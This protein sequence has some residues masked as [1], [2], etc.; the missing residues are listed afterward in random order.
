MAVNPKRRVSEHFR[1]SIEP[2][3]RCS[4][5]DFQANAR[6][7]FLATSLACCEQSRT[8]SCPAGQIAGSCEADCTEKTESW[9]RNEWEL[10]KRSPYQLAGSSLW[11]T[12]H[13]ASCHPSASCVDKDTRVASDKV[14]GGNICTPAFC[15]DLRCATANIFHPCM[16][17]WESWDKRWRN[18]DRGPYGNGRLHM[19]STSR[20]VDRSDR[21]R[22]SSASC[23]VPAVKCFWFWP[24][25]KKILINSRSRNCNHKSSPQMASNLMA[26]VTFVGAIRR[27]FIS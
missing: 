7:S 16:S 23:C 6:Q 1:C 11:G 24:N 18:A 9:R 22:C 8:F 26:V 25:W 3:R 17:L 20:D 13:T 15:G 21:S 27:C 10:W 2:S 4:N 19:T 12:L 5:E 14:L